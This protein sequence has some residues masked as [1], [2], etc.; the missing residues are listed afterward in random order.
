[1]EW[2]AGDNAA[3]D[4][5]ATKRE[6]LPRI[7]EASNVKPYFVFRA[8]EPIGFIQ[9]YIACECGDGWWEEETDPGVLGIDQFL[10][11]GSR[12]GQGLGTV[13]VRA[14]VERLLAQP[15]VT[16]I[17]TDPAPTNSR[18]IRCYEKAGFRRVRQIETPDGPAL[19]MVA[20]KV[21]PTGTPEVDAP[22][23]LAHEHH[24]GAPGTFNVRSSEDPLTR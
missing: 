13:M 22:C 24:R 8:N 1:M 12:L 15:G 16:K 23:F 2:W 5:E 18:A 7:H 6:Y 10:C 17:Q 4:F 9:S 11:D 20:E 14:F 19:L 21:K 3:P